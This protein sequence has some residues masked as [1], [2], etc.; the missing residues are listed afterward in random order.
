MTATSQRVSLDEA[1]ASDALRRA[2]P[3]QH[4]VLAAP[5]LGTE[6][7]RA[8][9]GGTAPHRE[10]T[11]HELRRLRAQGALLGVRCGRHGYLYPAFQVDATNGCIVP[12][13]ARINRVLHRSLTL[14]EALAWW[15]APIS[16]GGAPRR[17][18]VALDADRLAEQA[19]Q[20]PRGT[21]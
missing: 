18:S 14:E 7:M 16:T 11:K 17:E 15:A 13:V 9:L 4:L 8:A 5:H 10:V 20:A 21:P 6:G 19:Q 2:T 3:L 12:A 1:Q